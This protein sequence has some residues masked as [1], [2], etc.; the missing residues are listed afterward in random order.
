MV[1]IVKLYEESEVAEH[2]MIEGFRWSIGLV[3]RVLVRTIVEGSTAVMQAIHLDDA[4][5]LQRALSDAPRSERSTWQLGVRVG[6]Q[7]ISPLFWALRTGAQTT[8]RAMIED[9][10]TIRADRDR[11]YYGADELFHLQPDIVEDVLNEAPNLTETLLKGLIWRSHKT[12][13]GQRPVIYY[14]KHLLQDMDEANSLSRALISLVKFKHPKIITH[15]ILTFTL[16]M[17]LHSKNL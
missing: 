12:E 11:Y 1:L 8:A 4:L 3:S 14:L 9:V 2:M 7:S 17:P 16:D 15:P 10:L 6:S 13:N 5:H